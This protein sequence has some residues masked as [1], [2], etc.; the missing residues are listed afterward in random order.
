MM[1]STDIDAIH[2]AEREA[3]EEIGLSTS[4]YSILGC[5]P[6]I[7]DSHAVMITPV[8]ALLK[9]KFDNFR[10]L[11]DETS[12]AFYLDLEPFL[13]RKN[14]YR[15]TNIGNDFVTHQFDIQSNHI[16]GITAFQLI[17]LATVIYRQIP[18]FP[19]FRHNQQLDLDNLSQQL[20]EHFHLCMF[21]QQKELIRTQL[22]EIDQLK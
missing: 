16:W 7:A 21:N 14:N 13:Y 10:L 6:P 12:D 1:D 8:V 15:I 2:T 19:F 18:E 9:S 17:V 4:N 20:K 3:E 5:L 22:D 11:H